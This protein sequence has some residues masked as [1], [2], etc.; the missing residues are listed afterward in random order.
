[1]DELVLERIAV[2]C[3]NCI[4]EAQRISEAQ[5][6]IEEHL[7]HYGPIK[8]TIAARMIVSI[9]EALKGDLKKE[10]KQWV[11]R[12]LLGAVEILGYGLSILDEKVSRAW[13]DSVIRD[14]EQINLAVE[15]D[16]SFTWCR[17]PIKEKQFM[18][19]VA[20]RICGMELAQAPEALK[21]FRIQLD[22]PLELAQRVARRLLENAETTLEY[23]C[24]WAKFTKGN[25]MESAWLLQELLETS[26]DEKELRTELRRKARRFMQLKIV[27][28][29]IPLDRFANYC[30]KLE[31]L[32][33]EFRVNTKEALD[34][35][36]EEEPDLLVCAKALTILKEVHVFKLDEYK[37]WY[38]KV[39]SRF[40]PELLDEAIK[41]APETTI[42]E[43]EERAH[44]RIISK[45]RLL[46]LVQAAKRRDSD[47]R[48][49]A[50][51]WLSEVKETYHER[52]ESLEKKWIE[53]RQKR[54]RTSPLQRGTIEFICNNPYGGR[55][56]LFGLRSTAPYHP[57]VLWSEIQSWLKECG[58]SPNVEDL[59]YYHIWD[60]DGRVDPEAL[61]MPIDWERF[62]I[63]L[64]VKENPEDIEEKMDPS[65]QESSVQKFI[66]RTR[67]R[68]K[69]S[70]YD[71]GIQEDGF[72]CSDGDEERE[73]IR[74]T[75]PNVARPNRGF[76]EANQR[77]AGADGSVESNRVDTDTEM[78]E[79]D[80]P[81]R[82][83]DKDIK[84]GGVLGPNHAVIP[85]R[86]FERATH[87]QRVLGTEVITGT[88]L[89]NPRTQEDVKEESA[90][91]WTVEKQGPLPKLEIQ[92]KAR[93]V[94]ERIEIRHVEGRLRLKK[95]RICESEAR[96]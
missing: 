54:P 1:M 80:D 68:R 70:A 20:D 35:K 91:S 8:E 13:W 50:E 18:E 73:D 58:V 5:R 46:D 3:W 57:E 62:A 17:I 33:F 85:G 53:W 81:S 45:R 92:L 25:V 2:R 37:G 56:K 23:A 16:G 93:T 34:R 24:V 41:A 44:V 69:K 19:W 55:W 26:H 87:H 88:D 66:K 67:W 6:E 42:T 10:K 49:K 28:E 65:N 83:D 84:R 82:R 89:H 75:V 22:P 76:D 9:V 52:Y 30:G 78:Q 86:H 79:P 40:K 77:C 27:E 51:D 47:W 32:G 96:T 43:M 90:L 36:F 39:G 14:R 11:W 21:R 38:R 71:V 15:D 29:K 48:W 74:T 4:V 31:K 60:E 72:T 63:L 61:R 94:E 59:N 95:W 7:A 12:R 64:Q